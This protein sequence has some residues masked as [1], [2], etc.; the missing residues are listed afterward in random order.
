MDSLKYN[1]T[2]WLTTHKLKD[3]C[4]EGTKKGKKCVFLTSDDEKIHVL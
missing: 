1:L 3:L 2:L 4:E